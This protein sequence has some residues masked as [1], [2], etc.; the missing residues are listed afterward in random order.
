MVFL[1]KIELFFSLKVKSR[2]RFFWNFFVCKC[3]IFFF[4]KDSPH[5]SAS[6]SLPIPLFAK[7]SRLGYFFN[8]NNPQGESYKTES[9][10]TVA[11]NFRGVLQLREAIY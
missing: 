7:N 3:L 11:E 6:L 5:G 2:N 10:E 9:V 4:E 8:A 1:R